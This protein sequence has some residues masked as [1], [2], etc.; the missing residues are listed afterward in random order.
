MS[1]KSR[2]RK[3]KSA[4]KDKRRPSG[5]PANPFAELYRSMAPRVA[6]YVDHTSSRWNEELLSD[7]YSAMHESTN[8]GPGINT[9]MFSDWVRYVERQR[10]RPAAAMLWAMAQV[11]DAPADAEAAAAAQRL[12]DAGVEAPAWLAPLRKL[13]AT[14]AWKLTDVFGDF[15]ELI[16]EFRTGRR[17]HGIWISIDTNHM[18]GYATDLRVDDSA[19]G[20]VKSAES[21]LTELGTPVR[22]ESLALSEARR[23]GIAAIE[24]TD[25]TSDPDIGPDYESRRAFIL[26][27]LL[28]IPGGDVVELDHYRTLSEAEEAAETERIEAEDERLIAQFMTYVQQNPAHPESLDVEEPFSR[29]ADLALM[30]GRNYDDGRLT[31]VSPDKIRNFAG[32]F[33][34]RKFLL[35]DADKEA[36][37]HFLDAWISWCAIQQ[38]LPESAVEDV[39]YLAGATLKSVDEAIESGEDLSS[40]GAAFLEGVDIETLDD[41]NEVIARRQLAMPYYGTRIGSEDYPRL[42]P[43]RPDEL[44]LLVLG[45]L[46]D[47][48]G[49]GKKEY[50]RN[51]E[52]DGTPV[53]HGALRELVVSQLWHE[54]PPQVWE[55]AQRLQAQGLDRPAILDLLQAALAGHVDAAKLRPLTDGT[56]TDAVQLTGYIATLNAVSAG[57]RKGGHLR[58]V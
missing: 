40:P 28:A 11:A 37:P 35:D 52:P 42:N 41:A 33:L 30:Y 3:P 55:A 47:L 4:A 17:K 8:L 31:R 29:L 27:R 50:P 15:V 44:R 36:L 57:N 38:G 19:R 22:V 48:H 45:E 21:F 54:D 2:T 1:P 49:V 39:V 56:S 25:I 24:T 32:W 58:P 10:E 34:P 51:A 5:P 53:W 43:N 13:E 12:E 7:L 46:P 23:L 20:L 14:A 9:R 26:S 6:E 16:I 18:G